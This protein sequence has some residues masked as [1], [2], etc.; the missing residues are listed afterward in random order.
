MNN[1]RNI[2]RRSDP[3]DPLP[4]QAPSGLALFFQKYGTRIL[5]GF[6]PDRAGLLRS[7]DIGPRTPSGNCRPP[8]NSLMQA[9]SEITQ[10]QEIAAGPLR[11]T[12]SRSPPRRNQLYGQAITDLS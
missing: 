2:E 11:A 8:Q 4:S 3:T 5:I 1:E 6:T 9:R 12:P 7:F 10:L